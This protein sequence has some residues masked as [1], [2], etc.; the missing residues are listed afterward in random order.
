MV[1]EGGPNFCWFLLG[2]DFGEVE[3]DVIEVVSEVASEMSLLQHLPHELEVLGQLVENVERPVCHSIAL[4]A[5]PKVNR[6]LPKQPVFP[7]FGA[8]RDLLFSGSGLGEV[9]PVVVDEREAVDDLAFALMVYFE[10]VLEDVAS[11][12]GGVGGDGFDVEEEEGGVDGVPVVLVVLQGLDEVLDEGDWGL[13]LDA[14]E[15]DR[16]HFVHQRFGGYE[17][18]RHLRQ[19]RG[20]AVVTA[21]SELV[22]QF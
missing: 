11:E 17:V 22:V 3:E 16:K 20:N 1:E 4:D 12:G 9:F 21:G 14:L 13:H 15:Q 6:Y 18:V 7:A 8:Q 10:G 2:L 5:H 19:H